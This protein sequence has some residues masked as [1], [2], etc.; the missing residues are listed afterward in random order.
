PLTDSPRECVQFYT[1]E[2]SNPVHGAGLDGIEIHGANAYLPD[3]FLNERVNT[4]TDT[5]GGP[6]ENRAR[7]SLQAVEGA[8]NVLRQERVG[9]RISPWG[10]S[11]VSDMALEN[12]RPTFSHLVN[13]LRDRFPE[14]A[15]RHVVESEVSDVHRWN[16]SIREIWA[17]HP[18]ISC[19]GYT[20]ETAIDTAEAKGDSIA[21]LVPI[22]RISF[23]LPIVARH[24]ARGGEAPHDTRGSTEPVRHTDY[25]FARR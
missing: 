4:R 9:F 25:P 3:Q 20:R 16:D 23:T 11:T 12:P 17:T 14:L 8:V 19:G 1:T 22:S 24:R 5:Y 21:F 2:A 6:V 10:L 13:K 18:L 15:Y 7:F